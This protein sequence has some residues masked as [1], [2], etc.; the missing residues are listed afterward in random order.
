MQ[1]KE[2]QIRPIPKMRI[3]IRNLSIGTVSIKCA[4]PHYR[5]KK[6][7]HVMFQNYVSEWMLL[8]SP[9]YYYYI[10]VLSGGQAVTKVQPEAASDSKENQVNIYGNLI[11]F[12]EAGYRVG[13]LVFVSYCRR[14]IIVL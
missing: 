2:K 14:Q 3:L 11:L 10:L 9:Q 1:D 8:C 4:D 7:L 13:I 5:A 6:M 12:I